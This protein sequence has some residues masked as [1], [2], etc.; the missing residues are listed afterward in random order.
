MYYCSKHTLS[1]LLQNEIV[2]VHGISQQGHTQVAA[3]YPL[4]KMPHDHKKALFQQFFFLPEQI[5]AAL[6][7]PDNYDKY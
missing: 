4:C 2:S 5:Q 1:F 6:T 7:T 3:S